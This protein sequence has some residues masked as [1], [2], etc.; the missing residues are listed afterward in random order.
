MSDKNKVLLFYP[1]GLIYQRGEDRCQQAV[2]GSSAEAM[3][4]CNDLGYAAAVLLKK[5]YE[6]RLRDYQTERCSIEQM[7]AEEIGE[8]M[9]LKVEPT[10]SEEEESYVGVDDEETLDKVF[11]IFKEKFQ[12]E[13]NYVE[14]GEGN[15]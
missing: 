5:G 6:I 3:R 9:I 13:F 8:V 12:D 7:N 2:E 14:D 15:N 10:E 4:A 11:Q 1:P